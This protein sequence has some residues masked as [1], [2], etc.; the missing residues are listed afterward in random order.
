MDVPE[1]EKPLP[2]R[3]FPFAPG[4]IGLLPSRSGAVIPG[5]LPS[6]G[7]FFPAAGNHRPEWESLAC[8]KLSRQTAQGQSPAQPRQNAAKRIFG[9][10]V[11]TLPSGT[12]PFLFPVLERAVLTPELYTGEAAP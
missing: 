12:A 6:A 8:G 1:P 3:F 5:L 7:S 9:N 4:F 10:G 2:G 11:K